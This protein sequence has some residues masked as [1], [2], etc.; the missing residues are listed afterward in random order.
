MANLGLQ[1][2][3]SAVRAGNLREAIVLLDRLTQREPGNLRAQ[4]AL[5]ELARETGENALALRSLHVLYAANPASAQ[6]A[7]AL[8]LAHADV[9]NYVDA[10]RIAA[11]ALLR[12]RRCLD[13]LLASSR[14]HLGVGD[15]KG[16]LSLA[17]RA[18]QAAPQ[19]ARSHFALALVHAAN[20]A[21]TG[22]AIQAYQRAVTLSPNF[23]FAWSNLARCLLNLGRHAEASEAARRAAEADASL[24]VQSNSLFM[25]SIAG[26]LDDATLF[27]A[28]RSAGDKFAEAACA[29]PAFVAPIRRNAD[30]IS[31]GYL[32]ADFREHVVARLILPILEAHD[33][34]RFRIV[35]FGNTAHSDEV[36]RRLAKL[37]DQFVD[38]SRLEDSAALSR[39]RDERL[40]A[41]I[42]LSGHTAGNRLVLLAARAA[43]VQATWI[44][45][46]GTTGV[47]GVDLRFSDQW[48]DPPSAD[49]LSSEEIVRLTNGVAAYSISTP[50]DVAL[51]ET[52]TDCASSCRFGAIGRA[53]KL[54]HQS[55]A[56]WAKVM[57]ANPDAHLT[58][59][60]VDDIQLKKRAKSQLLQYGVQTSRLTFVASVTYEE[61]L[62]RLHSI[63]V[64]LDSTP[65]SSGASAYDALSLGI[66]IVCRRRIRPF[67]A[68]SASLLGRVGLD[69]LIADTDERYVEAATSIMR[70][71]SRRDQLRELLPSV[72]N[73]RLV[74][75]ARAICAEV[76]TTIAERL[77]RAGA[78][79][80]EAS[81]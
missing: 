4:A 76:E 12:D 9:G 27:E 11:D 34:T 6:L 24:V 66:P 14:S 67:G 19:N 58:I 23:P 51:T 8:A 13:A 38:L 5:A 61:Y 57:L 31:I 17:Q 64:V 18:V 45:Y 43:P 74:R 77:H 35:L 44:G 80:L 68:T 25:L 46:V 20:A 71:V 42:D 81:Y 75:C 32:S 78:T 33:R 65:Y 69:D 54:S 3:E 53:L 36:T 37:A 63:D 73:D 72:V 60:G 52:K 62:S 56:L 26:E 79:P 2:A 47:Q 29:M 21:T 16:A 22:L 59:M 55:V 1:E 41:L 30:R 50:K 15:N 39:M 70:D 49:A 28:H 48:I 10:Q 7:G 40:D